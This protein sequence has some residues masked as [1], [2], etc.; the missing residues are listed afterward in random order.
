MAYFDNANN[1]GFYSVSGGPYSYPPPNRTFAIDTEGANNQMFTD[2]TDQ[3]IMVR[4]SGSMVG[5]PTSLQATASSSECHS[6]PFIDS[7]LTYKPPESVAPAT[8]YTSRTDGCSWP[9]YDRSADYRQAQSRYSG[10]LSRGSSF[11]ET[12]ASESSTEYSLEELDVHRSQTVRRDYWGANQSEATTSASYMVG[13]Q[14]Q[15]YLRN[16]ADTFPQGGVN[17]SYW[18]STGPA[19][20]EVT[21][22]EWYQPYRVSRTR[23]NGYRNAEAGPSTLVAPPVP[24]IGRPPTQPSGGISETTANAKTTRYTI[25]E[26][27]RAPVSNFYCSH[28][29]LLV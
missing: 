28:I 26:E 15:S 19:R 18:P 10:Y 12:T 17:T 1:A 23:R 21:H 11:A 14:F 9:S 3:W 24:Y 16:P 25:T 2:T 8:P 20:A 4:G 7:W 29:P 22:T 5:Q 6:D 13:V 27:H